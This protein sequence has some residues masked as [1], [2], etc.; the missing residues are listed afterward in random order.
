MIDQICFLSKN[1][2]LLKLLEFGR[3][4]EKTQLVATA[5]F[6]HVNIS[7]DKDYNLSIIRELSNKPH[8]GKPHC[9]S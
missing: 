3:N 2:F 4:M 9:I 7:A 8:G 1:Q 6:E 5:Q